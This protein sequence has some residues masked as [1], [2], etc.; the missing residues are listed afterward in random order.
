V[1]RLINGKNIWIAGTSTA[2]TAGNWF[3]GSV[4]VDG[5]DIDVDGRAQLDLAGADQHLVNPAFLRIYKSCTKNIGTNERRHTDGVADRPRRLRHRLADGSG[6]N[7]TSGLTFESSWISDRMFASARCTT[8]RKSGTNGF[9]CVMLAGTNA[10]NT[11]LVKGGSVSVGKM[12]PGQLST[13]G[14]STSPAMAPTSTWD[15]ASPGQR[16]TSRPA[17]CTSASAGTTLNVDGG[18]A[19]TSGSG[20]ITTINVSGG[21]LT[22]NSTGAVTDLNISGTATVDM[23]KT[24]ASRTYTNCTLSGPD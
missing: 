24:T 1:R 9:S 7:T 5:D 19:D 13:F 20:A 6:G 14:R 18:A 3:T 17:R 21:T 4:P 22:P 16:S 12:T 23:S 2:P 10:S 8:R 11:L 15:P